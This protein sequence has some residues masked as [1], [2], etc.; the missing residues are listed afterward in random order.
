[1]L[2]IIPRSPEQIMEQACPI[3]HI[4]SFI[5]K[6]R[7]ITIIPNTKTQWGLGFRRV[8]RPGQQ[9]KDTGVLKN[10]RSITP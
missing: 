3:P 10:Q 7:E 2:K 5:L 9:S 6:T 4:P 1:M 8:V